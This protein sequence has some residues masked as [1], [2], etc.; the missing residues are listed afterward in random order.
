[1]FGQIQL[2]NFKPLTAMPQKFATAWDATFG[3]EMTGANFNPLLC[4]GSQV[5]NGTNF[6][7]LAEETI[8]CRNPIR[9]VV[10]LTIHQD[11][12]EYKL[13]DDS[14]VEII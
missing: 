1:M 9:R 11:G 13:L 10:R 3:G 14:I 5:V 6:Y 12:N 2:E 4:L 8:I 7:F